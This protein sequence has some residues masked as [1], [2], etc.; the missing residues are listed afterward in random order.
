MLFGRSLYGNQNI[1]CQISQTV[2]VRNRCAKK[3]LQDWPFWDILQPTNSCFLIFNMYFMFIPFLSSRKGNEGNEQKIDT[4]R[5]AV[6][7]KAA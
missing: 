1:G 3:S 5:V 7:S 6:A 2:S 4:G